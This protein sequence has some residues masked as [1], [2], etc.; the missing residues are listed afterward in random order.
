MRL[1][2]L[3]WILLL[4][5][6]AWV[7]FRPKDSQTVRLPD[8]HVV[9]LL[10]ASVGQKHRY[11]F[12]PAWFKPLYAVF[13]TN[14]PPWF[15]V[16]A[17]EIT[18]ANATLVCW[19]RVFGHPLAC[20]ADHQGFE[21][22]P[23]DEECSR[24]LGTNEMV[25]GYEFSSFP[26]RQRD[27]G[28]RIWQWGPTGRVDLV[29]FKV[30][31]PARRTY[32]TWSPEMLPCTKLAGDLPITLTRLDTGLYNTIRGPDLDPTWTEAV[33]RFGSS[34]APNGPWHPDRVELSDATGNLV[35]IQPPEQRMLVAGTQ[36]PWEQIAAWMRGNGALSLRGM[37]W[38][39]EPAWK[40][41]VTYRQMYDAPFAPDKLWTVRRLL[42]PAAG[43]ITEL[44][45]RT[46]LPYATILLR[47]LSA[48]GVAYP[49]EKAATDPQL[50]LVVE[51]PATGANVDIVAM[52]D[53]RGTNLFKVP[54]RARS[55][56][57]SFA[58]RRLPKE[59]QSLDVTFAVHPSYE[60]EFLVKPGLVR[61]NI[62]KTTL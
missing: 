48:A 28:L 10:S 9:T 22:R 18:N 30:K 26:R 3:L 47:G 51:A 6:A 35:R 44:D 12:G 27:F 23:P 25:M 8:G 56:H 45:I 39:D 7:I 61:T 2:T 15:G 24:R 21:S 62:A 52:T 17:L 43:Q 19:V 36:P 33:F 38:L 46:N 37:L 14:L 5:V 41:R 55:R 54:E 57:H 16:S 49:G 29:Q 4:L 40:L 60:V 32:P 11:V 31:N 59:S 1:R 13:Q 50:H 58:L 20:L 42:L 53:D 34:E